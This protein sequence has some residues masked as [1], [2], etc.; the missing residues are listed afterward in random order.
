MLLG[1]EGGQA[2]AQPHLAPALPHLG[3]HKAGGLGEI[4]GKLVTNDT[5]F[6]ALAS[7]AVCMARGFDLFITKSIF[8]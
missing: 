4:V 2:A 1:G 6:A 8:F 3:G 7:S 5:V